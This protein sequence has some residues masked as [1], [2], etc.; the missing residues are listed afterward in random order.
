MGRP[1]DHPTNIK[2]VCILSECLVLICWS[3]SICCDTKKR[4]HGF[5][6]SLSFSSF[7]P[8]LSHTHTHSSKDEKRVVTLTPGQI[9]D[10]APSTPAST[11]T[12]EN[13]AECRPIWTIPIMTAMRQWARMG[14]IQRA[15]PSQAPIM[16][17]FF[18]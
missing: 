9:R 1:V 8:P 3:I 5:S 15:W 4:E 2:C 14:S 11:R 6:V 13:A 12:T 18:M 17:E 10:E 16:G 7:Q